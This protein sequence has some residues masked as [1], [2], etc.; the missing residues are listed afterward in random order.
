MFIKEILRNE[1]M[2]VRAPRTTSSITPK[3]LSDSI[4]PLTPFE[5]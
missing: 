4:R 2:Q 5:G 3:G 1:F